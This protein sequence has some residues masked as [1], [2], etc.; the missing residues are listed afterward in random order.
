LPILV[1]VFKNIIYQILE[2]L[3]KK[4]HMDHPLKVHKK[5]N[6][7][8]FDFEF[9]TFLLL[10]MQNNKILGKI[11]LIR[12]LWGELRLFRIVLRL[13]GMKKFFKIGQIFIYFSN[14]I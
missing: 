7:F 1:T 10:V 11:F 14:H 13:R 6:F 8:G 5:D 4:H 9:C 2:K 3:F 12:P